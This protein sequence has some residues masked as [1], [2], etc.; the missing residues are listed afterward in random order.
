MFEKLRGIARLCGIAALAFG[1]TALFSGCGSNPTPTPSNRPPVVV[2]GIR[3]PIQILEAGQTVT[4]GLVA[5][6]DPDGDALVFSWSAGRGTVNP[7]GPVAQSS[8]EYTAPS[9]PGQETVTV[10]IN[11][12]QGGVTSDSLTFNVVVA[13]TTPT[14]AAVATDTPMPPP[15][16]TPTP[17]PTDRPP[18]TDTPTPA[19]TDTP[20]PEPVFSVTIRQPVDGS[21]VSM[22]ITVDGTT[23]QP[24]P[25]GR[26]LWIVVEIGDLWWPQVSCLTPFPRSGALDF[27]WSTSANVGAPKDENKTFNIHAILTTPEIDRIFADWEN[28]GRATGQFPGFAK[29]DLIRQGAEQKAGITVMRLTLCPD[30]PVLV[31]LNE[32][33]TTCGWDKFNS[34]DFEEA[35]A[36]AEECIDT[37]DAQAHR[38]QEEFTASG[39]PPPPVGA[40]GEDVKNAI[41]S[42]GVLNDVATCY[43]IKGQATEGLDRINQALLAYRGAERFPDARTY[44]PRGWF[45]SPAEAATDRIARLT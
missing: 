22:S 35:I 44:D 40:V 28:T 19:A 45:W 32:Q 39:K 12:G 20:T 29:T 23:N 14:L 41:L 4:L 1:F 25:Q 5:V 38:E 18:P 43:Y 9:T 2:E 7:S 13:A 3:L 16:D 6:T 27:G 8:V 11:D 30:P 26:C 33:L 21:Q 10:T 17:E 31:S 15:T 34:R 37:F 24:V 36:I 42:R